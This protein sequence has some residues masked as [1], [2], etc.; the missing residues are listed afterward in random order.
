MCPKI[1]ADLRLYRDGLAQ[2]RPLACFATRALLADFACKA[3]GCFFIKCSQEQLRRV[4]HK[5]VWIADGTLASVRLEIQ[6]LRC[7]SKESET[8]LPLN[9][10]FQLQLQVASSHVVIKLIDLLNDW[11]KR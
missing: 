1:A 11:L 7:D 4:N 3:A 2:S 5:A 6:S 9:S 10:D 8:T